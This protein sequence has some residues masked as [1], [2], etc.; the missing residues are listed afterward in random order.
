MLMHEGLTFEVSGR[1]SVETRMKLIH[2]EVTTLKAKSSIKVTLPMMVGQ[3]LTPDQVSVL[4]GSMIY[5]EWGGEPNRIQE[6]SQL[7]AFES[8]KASCYL[9]FKQLS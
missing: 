4:Y 1:L 6:P 3:V 9:I 7:V 2:G 8:N 5:D